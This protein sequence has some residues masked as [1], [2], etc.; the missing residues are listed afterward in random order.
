MNEV[1]CHGIPDQRILLDGDIINLDVSLYHEGYHADLNETYYVGE[2]AK[3][4]AD[5]VRVIETTR[6]CLDKAIEIVKPG[7]PIRDFGKVIEKHAK[8]RGCRIVSTWGGQSFRSFWLLSLC[9]MSFAPST[10]LPSKHLRSPTRY[11]L[12]SSSHQE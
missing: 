2:R 1:I 5:T 11:T 9:L 3:A 6:E 8:S 7:T 4:D 10:T 12:S